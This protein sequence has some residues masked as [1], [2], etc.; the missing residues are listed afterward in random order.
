MMETRIGPLY[1]TQSLN[2]FE[3]RKPIN[4]SGCPTLRLPSL[5]TLV[6]IAQ[7]F[8]LGAHPHPPTHRTSQHI[9]PCHLNGRPLRTSP[10][11][12]I[13]LRFGCTSDPSVLIVSLGSILGK[14]MGIVVGYGTEMV[15]LLVKSGEEGFGSMAP[16]VEYE[17]QAGPSALNGPYM[18]I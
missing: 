1:P 11:I 12:L 10:L 18:N 8:E 14:L 7:R 5:N 15:D 2:R 3:L 9:L 6:S 4:S 17:R 13:I 16:K